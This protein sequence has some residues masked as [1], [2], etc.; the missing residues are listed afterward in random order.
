MKTTTLLSLAV[1]VALTPLAALAQSTA[2]SAHA[3]NSLKHSAAA[4]RE[5]L[6]AGGH[7]VAGSVRLVS[8]VAAV[9]V[10]MSGAVVNG[11]G[12]ALTE[13][14][15]ATTEAADKMWDAAHGDPAKRPALDR[16]IGL[17]KPTKTA[18]TTPRD[19][20][21]AEALKRTRQ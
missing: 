5:A 14:G 2:A 12:T 21:P 6:L 18:A 3:A 11:I 16:E 15:K 13:S 7:S 17:P 1:A 4:S 10:W 20:S 9:P 19:P 8:G